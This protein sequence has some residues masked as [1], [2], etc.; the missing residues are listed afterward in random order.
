MSDIKHFILV[1]LFGENT[2][3]NNTQK[4]YELLPLKQRLE[5]QLLI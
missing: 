2:K 1:T 3:T 4:K 5:K